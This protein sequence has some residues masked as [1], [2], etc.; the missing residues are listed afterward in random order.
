MVAHLPDRAVSTMAASL[1]AKYHIGVP[2]AAN[3]VVATVDSALPVLDHLGRFD[4]L[5]IDECHHAPARRYRDLI[6]RL[7]ESNSALRI[8]GSTA[9][10]ERPDFVGLDGVIGKEPA[11]VVTLDELFVGG[12]LVPPR[13]LAEP[14]SGLADLI[15]RNLDPDDEESLSAVLNAEVAR[16]E[17]VRLCRQFT[18][19]RQ[20]IIYCQSV[21]AAVELA[22][23]LCAAGED[24]ACVSHKTRANDRVELLRD[25]RSGHGP[26]F[27]TNPVLLT[28]GFDAPPVSC[29]VIARWIVSRSP[30]I[31]QVGRGL[32]PHP[33]KR[34]C[35][36]IDP[37][38]TFERVGGLVAGTN[39]LGNGGTPKSAPTGET[40]G[41]GRWQP[42]V[43]IGLG[44]ATLQPFAVPDIPAQG[45]LPLDAPI[46]DEVTATFV[47]P[48]E[49]VPPPPSKQRK[50]VDGKEVI[51]RAEAMALGLPRYF[52]GKP[53]P[54]G[55][56]AEL[57]I[58]ICKC[59]ECGA[60][61]SRN[62][63]PEERARQVERAR[64][65]REQDPEIRKREAEVMRKLR[66]EDPNYRARRQE[67]RHEPARRARELERQRKR[68]R[69]LMKDPEYRAK[70]NEYARA[71]TARKKDAR[72][73]KTHCKHGH[74]FTPENT[75]RAP[76]G[77]R[78]CRHCMRAAV[79]RWR[80]ST[81]KKAE[82][83]KDST[84]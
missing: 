65:R 55:H 19:E 29:I 84:P 25:F 6:A 66:R 51:S 45:P 53:C 37:L 9:T 69:E 1:A 76:D 40:T 75:G 20:T 62:R 11:A 56:V 33:G 41:E 10:P 4:L 35:L 28:E 63:T 7:K 79:R 16:Q 14:L 18:E 17:I 59:V 54:N 3:V 27:L 70:Q 42:A 8:G 15:A 60:E 2:A 39:L 82:A 74:E 68:R 44:E 49:S 50:I 22:D 72:A 73:P 23:A 64:R 5:W 78:R 38:A 21:A 34:D 52:T 48:A 46:Q 81:R 83:Q 32:R 12:W 71:T 13:V 24:A 58:S 57:Y 61:Q 31:Q 43:T 80:D 77:T 30:L 47:R 36:V 67:W 26:R